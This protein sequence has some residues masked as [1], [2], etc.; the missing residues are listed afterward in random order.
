MFLFAEFIHFCYFLFD[1]CLFSTLSYYDSCFW[2][3]NVSAELLISSIISI[4]IACIFMACLFSLLRNFLFMSKFVNTVSR[5]NW[6]LFSFLLLTCVGLMV[7]ISS[8]YSS[9]A[10]YNYYKMNQIAGFGH[11][12][13]LSFLNINKLTNIYYSID[14]DRIILFPICSV[15]RKSFVIILSKL[16]YSKIKY[17]LRWLKLRYLSQKNLCIFKLIY[18]MFIVT[19]IWEERFY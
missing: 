8:P 14:S 10:D 3:I 13:S 7:L 16:I 6:N 12:F 11:L 2:N 17:D 5:S 18:F 15:F 19:F 1:L 9:N 4:C